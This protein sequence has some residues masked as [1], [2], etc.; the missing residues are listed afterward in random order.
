MPKHPRTDREALPALMAQNDRRPSV[1]AT[2]ALIR[3]AFLFAESP[4][5]PYQ[6]FGM[7]LS[8]VDVLG[9][10]A[11]AEGRPSAAPKLPR[12]P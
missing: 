2:R 5:R 11:R 3:A 9:A 1:V 12:Q 8:E 4:D 7:S 6:A 10:I